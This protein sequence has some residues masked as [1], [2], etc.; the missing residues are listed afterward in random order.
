MLSF[1]ERLLR[2]Y[3]KKCFK[4]ETVIYNDRSVGIKNPKTN[5]NLELD[6]FYP[7]L[8]VAFEFNGRQ[9]RTDEEQ[10]ERDKIKKKECK[11]LGI[12][13]FTIWTKDLNKDLYKDIKAKIL[14][15]SGFK[16]SKPNLEF[17]NLFEEKIEHY[18]KNIKKLHKN[19]KSDTFVKVVRCKKKRY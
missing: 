1:G 9:H 13:L 16:I 6:I 11:K 19:I 12:L 7:N 8:L 4:T 14:E 18:K 2:N 15:H 3:L 10:K 17:L 5:A